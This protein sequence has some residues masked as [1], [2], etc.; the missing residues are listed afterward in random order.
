[1]R[2]PYPD[3]ALYPRSRIL[4]VSNSH[5]QKMY[6]DAEARRRGLYNLEI[7]T[8]DMND[9]APDRKFDRVVSIEMFEHMRNYE[10]LLRR[11]SMWCKR[12]ARLFIVT[13][14]SKRR[15]SGRGIG[16]PLSHESSGPGLD[17]LK[18]ED[19]HLSLSSLQKQ[20]CIA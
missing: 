10:E 12:D 3:D 11:I 2:G 18:Y 8:A 14:P 15:D 5:S 1:M 16:A 7:V 9:F 20:G 4:G 6:I 17:A 13:S 19:S